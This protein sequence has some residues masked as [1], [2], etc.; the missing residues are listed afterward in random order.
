MNVFSAVVGPLNLVNPFPVPPY[1][2][3]MIPTSPDPSKDTPPTVLIF[4][5]V[6]NLILTLP[7]SFGGFGAREGLYLYFFQVLYPYL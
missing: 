7:V 2:D 6:V 4:V 1:V 3:A 5:P